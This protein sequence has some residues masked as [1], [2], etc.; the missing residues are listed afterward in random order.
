MW[1]CLVVYKNG[2]SFKKTFL[3]FEE[4]REFRNEYQNIN[5]ITSIGKLD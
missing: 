2:Y 3:T 4:A 5:T 1:Y